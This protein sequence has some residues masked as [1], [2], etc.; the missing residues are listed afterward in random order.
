VPE[1]V[2]F[3]VFKERSEQWAMK[4]LLIS[5]YGNL[6]VVKRL[7]VSVERLLKEILSGIT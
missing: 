2:D 3:A 6:V 5:W 7:F 1:H 4:L